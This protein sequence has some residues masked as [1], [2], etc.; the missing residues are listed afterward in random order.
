MKVE[1]AIFYYKEHRPIFKNISFE[2]KPGEILSIMGSNGAGKTTLI[3]CIAN[4]LKLNRGT[5]DLNGAKLS[6][7]PQGKKLNLAYNVLDFVSFG[8]TG[9][10][11]YFASPKPKDYE[12]SFETLKRLNISKLSE[13]NI[14]EVSGG[15]LQMCFFAKALVSEP[16][17]L[18]LD[19]P[20]SN[21]DFKNQK[22]IIELIKELAQDG[23]I[24]ILNTHFLNYASNISNKCLLMGDGEHEYGEVSKVLSEDNLNRYFQVDIK[25]TSVKIKDRI[26]ENYIII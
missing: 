17:I 22:R 8:R 3:K 19:E 25:K 5:I 11:P 9:L 15:E 21:L 10:N 7:V 13:K 23:T 14:N 6:Y 26:Y 16:D 24:V 20:E 2:L 18:I 1:D 12:M 4:I